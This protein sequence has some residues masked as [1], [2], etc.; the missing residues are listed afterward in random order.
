MIDFPQ[1]IKRKERQAATPRKGLAVVD[2]DDKVR[3]R[4]AAVLGSSKAHVLDLDHDIEREW[5]VHGNM[6]ARRVVC[7][8]HNCDLLSPVVIVI[9]SAVQHVWR[10]PLCQ[11]RSRHTLSLVR[12]AV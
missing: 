2:T 1:A 5:Q 3:I 4:L 11:P 7:V 8:M 6:T 12:C 10:R 9:G